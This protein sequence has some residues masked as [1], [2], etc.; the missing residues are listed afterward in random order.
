MAKNAKRKS[1]NKSEQKESNET[2]ITLDS[3]RYS[4]EP[5]LKKVSLLIVIQLVMNLNN[6]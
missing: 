3:V 2:S 6:F 1:S 4:D 5:P